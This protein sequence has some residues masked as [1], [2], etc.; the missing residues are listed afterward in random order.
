MAL[1]VVVTK[2]G[3]TEP[4]SEHTFGKEAR[5]R[6]ISVGSSPDNDIVL[7]GAKDNAGRVERQVHET[8][9]RQPAAGGLHGLGDVGFQ[10]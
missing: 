4:V 10:R 6:G 8:V 9:E 2:V 5:A 1:K 7:E 3:S